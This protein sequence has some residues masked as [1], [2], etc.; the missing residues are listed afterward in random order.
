MSKTTLKKI[1]RT[2]SL[3]EYSTAFNSEHPRE[4][5]IINLGGIFLLG[6]LQGKSFFPGCRVIMY[7]CGLDSQNR[8]FYK[9]RVNRSSQKP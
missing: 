5:G 3:V 9:F 4:F 1:Q 2:G 8:P 6:S 7:D